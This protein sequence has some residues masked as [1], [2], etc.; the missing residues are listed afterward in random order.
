VS[1]SRI[2]KGDEVISIA[3]T[4]KGR[5]GKVLHVDPGRGVAYVEGL[6]II[7]KTMRRSSEN[8]QG[9]IVKK[10]AAITLSNLMPYDPNA[11]KG[12]RIERFKDGDRK[13][14]RSKASNHIFDS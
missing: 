13:V 12:A 10:E 8:P 9:G 7:S 3:G 2:R 1:V 14:R 4:N 11:K 6:N 5:T